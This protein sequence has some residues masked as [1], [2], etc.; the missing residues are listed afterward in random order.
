M[1]SRS[2]YW[3]FRSRLN[4]SPSRPERTFFNVLFSRSIL[5]LNLCFYPLIC[6]VYVLWILIASLLIYLEDI[7]YSFGLGFLRSLHDQ[8]SLFLKSGCLNIAPVSGSRFCPRLLAYSWWNIISTDESFL[9]TL[10]RY[11]KPPAASN[12]WSWI[13]THSC[14]IFSVRIRNPSAPSPFEVLSAVLRFSHFASF[15]VCP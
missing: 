5:R 14:F 13:F 7:A 15:W 1:T 4:S 2:S 8:F 10:P 9:R 11:I 12:E 6:A 3:Q